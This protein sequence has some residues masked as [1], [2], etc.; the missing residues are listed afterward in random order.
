MLHFPI[1][2]VSKGRWENR[3]TSKA[4]EAMNIP[5]RIVIEPQ[6]FDQYASVIDPTKILVLPFS[7]LE[8]GS[9]PARNYIWELKKIEKEMVKRG[10]CSVESVSKLRDAITI[11]KQIAK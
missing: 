3:L 8:Q 2:I 4:L 5:Y 1:Y 9:I 11:L 10:Y 6:E 7:N